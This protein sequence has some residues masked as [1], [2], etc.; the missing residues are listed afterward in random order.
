MRYFLF[1]IL[2][3]LAYLSSANSLRF[4]ADYKLM[5][6]ERGNDNKYL[7]PSGNKGHLLKTLSILGIC[8]Y[9]FYNEHE[10]NEFIFSNQIREND[11]LFNFQLEERGLLKSEPNDP[12]LA[13]QWSL[14]KISSLRLRDEYEKLQSRSAGK[15]TIGMIDNGILTSHEDL[16]SI[17]WRNS[18]EIEGDGIDNDANGY[19]DDYFGYSTAG[20][21]S[22]QRDTFN[23]HGT[24]AAGIAAA[25]INNKKGIASPGDQSLMLFCSYGRGLIS[26]L[27][28][29][30][31]YI[32]MQKK[33]YLDSKGQKGANVIVINLS[34]G[35]RFAKPKDYPLLCNIYDKLGSLG[36]LSVCVAPNQFINVD[37]EGDV[38]CGCESDFI[39]TE[40]FTDQNDTKEY[41]SGFGKQ[42]I[43]LGVPGKELYSTYP[44][45]N[46]S[47][48][49]FTGNSAAGPL[50]TGAIAQLYELP[51]YS[52]D[53]FAMEYPA[54]TALLVKEAIMKNTDKI[55]SLAQYTKSGGRLNVFNAY[56]SMKLRLCDKTVEADKVKIFV[57]AGGQIKIEG[58]NN[59]IK[60]D[61]LR[62]SIFNDL[63]QILYEQ[64]KKYPPFIPVL[65][66]DKILNAGIYFI[67]IENSTSRVV[68]KFFAPGF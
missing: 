34:S 8:I 21:L 64:T 35:I 13:L 36:I 66:Q 12:F 6:R 33:T 31:E 48:N 68:K 28:E 23:P 2:V 19:I 29:C 37:E 1:A 51:C 49:Y 15:F 25:Q 17:L 58:L 30:Y 27:L 67:S 9:Q 38:P 60:N 16:R 32:A 40:T 46:S 20:N 47:Y 7:I 63:G 18:D 41:N 56:N 3:F 50:L 55:E 5:V 10:I 14:K 62:I 52:L 4:R 54:Q 57:L 45:G 43:D 59:V 22:M 26:D 61:E 39:I 44:S 65:I 11:Y 42:S 53:S 24:P